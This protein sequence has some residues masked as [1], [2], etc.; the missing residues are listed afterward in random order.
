MDPES[1]TLTFAAQSLGSPHV[2]VVTQSDWD[3]LHQ[4]VMRAGLEDFLTEEE[5]L[6]LSL[7]ETSSW[8]CPGAVKASV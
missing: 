1:C 5:R 4:L 2:V 8:T 3:V 6:R 7:I